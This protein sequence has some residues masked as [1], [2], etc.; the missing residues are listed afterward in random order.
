MSPPTPPGTERSSEAGP[1]RVAS[2][3][4]IVAVPAAIALGSVGGIAAER[5]DYPW[6]VGV[7]AGALAAVLGVLALPSVPTRRATVVLLGLGG[8]AALR[9]ASFAGTDRSWILVVW[10]SATMLTL[11][12][13]DRAD[14]EMVP[15]LDGG[16]P[17]ARRLPETAR[18]ASVVAV[19]VVVAAVVLVPTVTER[20]GRHVWPGQQPSDANIEGSPSSL[21]SNRQLDLTT[22][23]RLSNAVVFTVDAAHADFWRGETFDDYGGSAWTN[24]RAGDSRNFLPHQD[25][26]TVQVPAARYD[27]GAESGSEFRQTFH[28]EAG[29]SE[30]VFAAPSPRVVETD[31][32]LSERPDGT[33]RVAPESGPGF[34]K[35]AVYTVYS[36]RLPVTEVTLRA[37]DAAAVPPEIA[38]QYAHAPTTSARVTALA[39]TIT[40]GESTT[41]DK[42]QAI[43]S[44]M[45]AN[46]KY[47][48]L[49]PVSHSRDVVD[50]FLFQSRLG[51]C[52]QIASSLVVLARSVGIP[53]RLV[54]G[55]APGARDALT[56]RFV[57]R[58]KDAH[59][60]AEIYFPGVGWQGFDPTATV[61][62]AG[63][64]GS[65][66][67]WLSAAR[68]NA[69][70]LAVAAALLVLIAAAAPEIMA[71]VR[72]R[73]ER[74]RSWSANALHRL[75]RAGRKVGRARAPAET[76]RQYA[77]ALAEKLGDDRVAGLGDTLDRDLYSAHG[78]SEAERA[79]AD[80]VL[81]SLRP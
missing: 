5:A 65:G 33:I 55:F 48:L 63:D 81:T 28:V 78:A 1:R 37:A 46:T 59:A 14:A 8:L 15:A 73:R 32:L 53:A 34:G 57:V 70:P 22:R 10:A 7:V 60:W 31:K 19:V 23:P 72:R 42:I 80:A 24:T 40:A 41:F 50:D 39:R 45:G 12:L 79:D 13:V 35:G 44:W 67:S 30:V 36:R 68:H 66:G 76:P 17:L 21:Q 38:A 49:A 77:Q 3:Y 4:R 2:A 27:I 18:V 29:F 56:G 25:G 61:P 11:V 62:L 43:E 74:R 64:A 47:S 9:H 26:T 16:M 54:T 71:A 69:V 51:W 20:L 52:E 6:I 75:E 58:E